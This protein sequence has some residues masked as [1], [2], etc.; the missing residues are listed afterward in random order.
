MKF[1]NNLRLHKA[2]ASLRPIILF[3]KSCFYIR[4]VLSIQYLVFHSALVLLYDDVKNNKDVN[5]FL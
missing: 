3:V 2:Q 4:F 5:K 1:K